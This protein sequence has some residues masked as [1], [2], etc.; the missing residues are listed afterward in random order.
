MTRT[1][2]RSNLLK[3]GTRI[4]NYSAIQGTEASSWRS[5]GSGA[6]SL[7]SEKFATSPTV[8]SYGGSLAN[9]GF[10]KASIFTQSETNFI[11]PA[12][13]VFLGLGLNLSGPGPKIKSVTDTDTQERENIRKH[14]FRTL[15]EID[16]YL[17][18][19]AKEVE[20]AWKNQPA[21]SLSTA[22]EQI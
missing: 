20:I 15:E 5:S 12:W 14:R 1:K 22:L 3:G 7:R 18:E 19:K 6:V 4:A 2:G 10:S 21:F 9:L 13:I 8:P 11:Y 17:R 16:P